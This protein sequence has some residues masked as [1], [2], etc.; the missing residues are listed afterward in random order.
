MLAHIAGIPVEETALS[1]GPV[2]LVSGGIIGVK[3][4][5]HAGR[6][7]RERG[8]RTHRPARRAAREGRS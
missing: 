8:R 6:R 5:E 4:R 7:R 3:L 1:I 2:F